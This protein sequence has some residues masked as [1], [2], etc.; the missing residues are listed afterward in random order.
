MIDIKPLFSEFFASRVALVS[1]RMASTFAFTFIAA[2]TF[3]LLRSASAHE[4]PVKPVKP[5]PLLITTAAEIRGMTVEKAKEN[6]TVRLTGVITYYDPEE[7]DLFVQDSTGG[8][9]VSLE[10]VKPTVAI[11][12][13]DVVEVQGVT[14]APDFAPQIGN[15][16]IK[17]VGRAALPPAR[18][19]SFAQMTSTKMDSQRVE[20]EGI[21]HR[22]SKEGQHLYLEVTTEGG[23][24]TGRIPFYTDAVLPQIVDAH[25][26]LRGTCGAQFNSMNQLTGVFINIPYPS[27][28]EIVRP[29]PAD[30]FNIR[31]HAIADLLR[32]NMTGNLGH[33]VR[34]HGVVTLYRPG[35]SIFVQNENGSI[36]AQTQ[37]FTAGIK[38]GD[39]VNVIGFPAVGAYEPAL[40]DSIFRKTGSGAI[41]QPLTLSPAEAL[42]GNFARNILFRSYDANLIRVTGR[43]T[44]K[45]L[46]PGEQTLL[47]QE[48]STVF[49]GR[50]RDAQIP[51]TLNALREGSVLQ[52]TG[53]CTIEVDENHQ[54]VRFRVGLRSFEDVVVVR[55]PPWWNLRRT[56]TLVAIMVLAVLIALMWAAML[57]RRVRQATR[58]LQGSKEAA[59]AANEAK[60]TFLATMS[61]EIRTPMNGIL[62]M[63]ELVLD[64]ELNAE[65]RESLG[66]VKFSAESL[67]T[68]INDILDF[69]KI[70]AGKLELEAIPFD[71]RESLGETMDTLGYRAH[72]KGLELMYDVHPDVPEAVIGDPGRLRQILVN[73]AGNSIKFTERGEVVVAVKAVPTTEPTVELEFTVKDTGVG[74]AADQQE[75]IFEAFSQVD[76][77]MARKYGG[78]GLGLAICTKLVAMMSGR[79]WVESVPQQG[80]TFHFTVMLQAQDK[81]LARGAPL[82]AEELKGMRALIVDDN[83]TNR[84]ILTGVC[85]RWGMVSLAVANAEAALRVL[86]AYSAEG[87]PFRLILLDAHM[88][89]MDGFALVEQMQKDSSLQHA[90]VM[91]LTSAGHIG[92]AARCRALGISA[93]LMK[94][95]RQREL[96][97]AICELLKT[98]PK[99]GAAALLTRYTLQEEKHHYRI[100]LAEDN[101]VNQTLAVR[102]LEKRGYVVSVAGDGLAAVEA[103]KNGQFDLV[104]MDIQMPGMDGFEATAAIRAK[105]KLSGGRLPIVAMTAHAIKGDEEKCIAAGMD[106]YVSKPIRTA[107]LFS[108]IERMLAARGG[109]AADGT[110]AIDPIII[111][112]N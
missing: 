4:H 28:M 10:V 9:W 100:L 13:G 66:L 3:T 91:M 40:H 111:R 76:G 105:E 64:T 21:V 56:L 82:Q 89:G 63:T 12:A 20:V 23:P 53:I 33:R 78:S 17:V 83:F 99:T 50:L 2:I 32:Y 45:S 51:E 25:V 79:I 36:Y 6:H 19:V 15:P 67:L 80:S 96:L 60:S 101:A 22:V 54:P 68:V 92:D 75:K 81:R 16:R 61:H 97:D 62:G 98:G 26:R 30:P 104:L 70:E 43:L 69:S 103:L 108:V 72:Q 18:R 112:A 34:I 95:I 90:T 37:Q 8:I 31:I 38:V 41:P 39:E 47:L 109:E 35:R 73:L 85:T 59:E 93:Y 44:G 29:P 65:Q 58:A 24:V 57:G 55:E 86:H 71:F 84:Q 102:L 7:P 27:E 52:L 94:P 74:I 107:E 42:K 14:E 11:R 110:G 5:A 46:N 77:S 106:G 49:E 87:R 88:P 48:G 1:R